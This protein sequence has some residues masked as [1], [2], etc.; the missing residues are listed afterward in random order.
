MSAIPRNENES[1]EDYK[2]RRAAD[3]EATKRAM[4]GKL[5]HNSY[6]D[7]IYINEE[8]NTRKALKQSFGSFRQF[9]KNT[10]KGGK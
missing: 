5:V 9:K 10:K 1:F 4:K 8:K 7:G 6:Y 2:V 3:N